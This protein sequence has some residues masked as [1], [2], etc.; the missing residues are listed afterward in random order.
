MIH[1]ID[2]FLFYCIWVYSSSSTNIIGMTYLADDK[3]VKQEEMKSHLLKGK[4]GR[5]EKGVGRLLTWFDYYDCNQSAVQ[6]CVSYLN[7]L[8][9]SFLI[10]GME[11]I[12]Y[13][14]HR[15]HALYVHFPALTF[16][17]LR[18]QRDITLATT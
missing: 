18:F 12:L 16:L 9:T 2:L 11:I 17:P 14:A 7:S 3:C 15:R 5:V 10:S 6:S 8:S 1:C 13:L 4:R